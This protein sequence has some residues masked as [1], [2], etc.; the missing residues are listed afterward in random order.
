[1]D[2]LHKACPKIKGMLRHSGKGPKT[3][4][5]EMFK[6][7]KSSG[8][9]QGVVIAIEE[10]TP[11]EFVLSAPPKAHL[12]KIQTSG[13]A[14]NPNSSREAIEVLAAADHEGRTN[15]LPPPPPLVGTKSSAEQRSPSPSHTNS[16]KTIRNDSVASTSPQSPV[17]RSMF[18]RYD[19]KIPL[20][21]QHYYP[22]IQS[23]RGSVKEQTSAST[24]SRVKILNSTLSK[25]GIGSR[26]SASQT[27]ESR[28]AP[29]LSTPEELLD[30][31]SVANG[32]GSQEAAD[33]YTL[34]L[35]WSIATLPTCQ[36]VC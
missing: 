9:S 15:R 29:T 34:G 23:L 32:Q 8:Q 14:L 17:M 12:P 35:S 28:L 26:G 21:K 7:P 11:S 5:F 30:L 16:S 6:M 10:T 1:M 4:E 25:T 31:W 20:A 27:L 2:P 33:T 19:P 22:S 18:P 3:T 36:S 24:A 13:T